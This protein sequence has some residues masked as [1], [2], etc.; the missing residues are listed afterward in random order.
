MI[1]SDGIPTNSKSKASCIDSN[2]RHRCE[3]SGTS[4]GLPRLKPR[5]EAR[6]SEIRR[7]GWRN[8]G[9]RRS[10]VAHF[11]AYVNDVRNFLIKMGGKKGLRTNRISSL[12]VNAQLLKTD[13][14]WHSGITMLEFKRT[15]N[16]T[17]HEPIPIWI[18]L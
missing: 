7:V 10:M 3:A 5:D 4:K 13:V 6:K 1:L 12:Q 18:R 17:L 9:N 15:H 8:R 11:G 2:L 16:P 14:N